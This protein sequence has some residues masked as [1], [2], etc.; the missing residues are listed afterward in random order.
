MSMAALEAIPDGD[1]ER[2]GEL[3]ARAKRG[4]AAAFEELMRR[5]ERMVL[6][7]ALRMLGGRREEAEDASQTVF[8]KMHGSLGRFREGEDVAPWLYRTTVNACRDA[9]RK[10]RRRREVG[11]EPAAGARDGGVGPEAAAEKERLREIVREGLARL[12]EKERAAVVLR[13]VEGMETREVAGILGT[14]EATVRSQVR[15]GRRKIREFAER[16]LRKRT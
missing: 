4:D 10:A 9:G 11:L 16:L 1:A 15:S 2:S 8:L 13:D 3:M 5:Y 12:P 14:T 7:T 6:R